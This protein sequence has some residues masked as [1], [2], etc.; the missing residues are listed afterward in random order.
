MYVV[1]DLI[2][3]NGVRLFGE[4]HN[5]ITWL[6]LIDG[7]GN[8]SSILVESRDVSGIGEASG[9]RADHGETCDTCGIGEVGE[10]GARYDAGGAE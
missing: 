7:S 6:Y 1:K 5:C 8:D 4:C 9:S 3:G 2:P 10:D